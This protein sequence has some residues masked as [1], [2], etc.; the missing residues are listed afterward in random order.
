MTSRAILYSRAQLPAAAS[1][2]PHPVTVP[3]VQAWG[4]LGVGAGGRTEAALQ[5]TGQM[6]DC[7]L[8]QVQVW[9][10]NV[11][12]KFPWP[13]PQP[14]IFHSAQADMPLPG[15]GN[16]QVLMNGWAEC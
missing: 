4:G 16:P 10:E 8:G 1:P 3:W 9:K 12:K 7:F 11:K 15:P 14:G 5:G 6:L 2:Q 13:F